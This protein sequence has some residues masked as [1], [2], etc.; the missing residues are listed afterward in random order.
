M[1]DRDGAPE[2][3]AVISD[4]AHGERVAAAVHDRDTLELLT[5][6]TEPVGREGT[7]IVGD[8]PEFTL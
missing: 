1:F 6:G 7:V 5:D 2:Q 8:L 3:G 4:G